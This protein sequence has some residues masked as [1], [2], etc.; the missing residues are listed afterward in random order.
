MYEDTGDY[1][2]AIESYLALI[3][4]YNED[5]LAE[6]FQ[7]GCSR[8]CRVDMDERL[9]E[10][11]KMG[12]RFYAVDNQYNFYKGQQQQLEDFGGNINPSNSSMYP[13]VYGFQFYFRPSGGEIKIVY[14]S[15]N[16]NLFIPQY[17]LED[18]F[19]FNS[20]NKKVFLLKFV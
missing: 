14:D 12:F 19:C 2:K 6:L 9:S 15:K 4:F 1:E 18:G 20:L 10:A 8:I 13:R 11:C 3:E 16:D 5:I 17:Y 7:D